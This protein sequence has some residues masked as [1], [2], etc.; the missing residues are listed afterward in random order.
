MKTILFASIA[1]SALAL[2]SASAENH[3]QVA[4]GGSTSQERARHFEIIEPKSWAEAVAIIEE[5]GAEMK[6]AYAEKDYGK[7]HELSY[8]LEV[9]ADVLREEAEELMEAVEEVHHA[10]EDGEMDKVEQKWP[11]LDT[12]LN[13]IAG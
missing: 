11:E 7:M 9:A 10:T 5:K 6:A 1:F 8:H 13:D 3:A 12:R 4:E 2:S